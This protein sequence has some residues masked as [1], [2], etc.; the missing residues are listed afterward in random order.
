MMI[1]IA[2][3]PGSIDNRPPPGKLDVRM[4]THPCCIGFV[5]DPDL[6]RTYDKGKK[7]RLQIR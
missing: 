5:R 1:H 7:C 6:K 2:P 4:L 3:N